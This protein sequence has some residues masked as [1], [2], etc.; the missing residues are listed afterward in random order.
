MRQVLV[1]VHAGVH[2]C[3]VNGFMGLIMY[4]TNVT[5][6]FSVLC[7]NYNKI[8]C[9]V[10]KQVMVVVPC[11]TCPNIWCYVQFPLDWN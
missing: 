9:S 11:K 6:L 2:V 1:G 7:N 5:T 10:Q 8:W 4:Q 3:T